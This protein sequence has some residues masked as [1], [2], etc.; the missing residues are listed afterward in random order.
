MK[1][2]TDFGEKERLIISIIETILVIEES[3]PMNLSVRRSVVIIPLRGGE[4]FTGMLLYIY[5]K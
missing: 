2:E 1:V 5:L 3:F 4:V